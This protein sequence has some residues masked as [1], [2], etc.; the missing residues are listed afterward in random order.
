MC[1]AS[2]GWVAEFRVAF[3]GLTNE[4]GQR[5]ASFLN[6]AADGPQVLPEGQVRIPLSVLEE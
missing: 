1:S 4:R 5:S 2:C 6:R 3:H